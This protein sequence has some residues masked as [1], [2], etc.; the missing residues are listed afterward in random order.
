MK[1]YQEISLLPDDEIGLGF[2]WQKVFQQVHIALVEHKVE[3]DQSLVAVGF[4]DYGQAKFPLGSKLRLFAQEQVTLEQL[5]IHRWLTRLEDYAHIKR[6]KPVPNDVTYVSFVRKQVKSPARIERDRQAKAVRWAQK[7]GLPLDECLTG[8][9]KSRPSGHCALPFIHLYSQQTKQRAPEASSRFPLFIAMYPA[10]KAQSAAF[11]CYGL[12]AK[13]VDR[14]Q[15][16][17]VPQ[18]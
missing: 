2:I 1:Y 9:E 14:T 10:D 11:D 15:W 6:I 8:L 18:F 5:A 12:S 4:P 16:A 7:S 13:G 17:T 3:S